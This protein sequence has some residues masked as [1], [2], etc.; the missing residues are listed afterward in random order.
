MQMAS[1]HEKLRP[2]FPRIQNAYSC[3]QIVALP[4][5]PKLVDAVSYFITSIF[6]YLLKT[7]FV[8]IDPAEITEM[9]HVSSRIWLNL[10]RCGIQESEKRWAVI[11]STH[12]TETCSGMGWQQTRKTRRKNGVFSVVIQQ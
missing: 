11:D 7:I 8:G 10:Q 4:G 12:G 2:N 9:F 6:D 3:D 1:G 5:K